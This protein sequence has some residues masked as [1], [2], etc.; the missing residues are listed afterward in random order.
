[1]HTY[2]E[3][4]W[5]SRQSF[6]ASVKPDQQGWERKLCLPNHIPVRSA[7]WFKCHFWQLYFK[8]D[9]SEIHF[10]SMPLFSL[11][12]KTCCFTSF[13][14][15]KKRSAAKSDINIIIEGERSI[16]A[17]KKDSS[18]T[19][20][21]SIRSTGATVVGSVNV[22]ELWQRWTLPPSFLLLLS[23]KMDLAVPQWSTLHPGSQMIYYNCRFCNSYFCTCFLHW[24]AIF[25]QNNLKWNWGCSMAVLI[26]TT[27]T[28]IIIDY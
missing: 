3:N 15:V 16:K 8:A 9:W 26:K 4:D 24:R 1:M 20:V 7:D 22:T 19:V 27:K 23:H 21:I 18:A 10:L 17:A 25:H 6:S 28:V 2:L 11:W 12:Q 5:D 13:T 14:H